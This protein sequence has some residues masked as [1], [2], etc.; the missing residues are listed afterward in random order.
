MKKL[1]AIILA[2]LTVVVLIAGCAKPELEAPVP[3]PVPKPAVTTQPPE[4]TPAP[5]TE[6]TPEPTPVTTESTP[7]PTPAPPPILTDPIETEY[8]LV[9]GE[10]IT[11]ADKKIHIYKGIPYAEP[12]LGDL[13]W[14]PPQPLAHWTGVRECTEYSTVAPQVDTYKMYGAGISEDCLYL[15]VL[16]PDEKP[17]ESLPVMVWLHGGGYSSGSGNDEPANLPGLPGHGVVLVT[18]NMRLGVL[19]LLAHPLL[20]EESTQGVSGNYMFLDMIAALKWVRDNIAAFGGDPDNVTIFGESGGGAKVA[21]LMASPLVKGLFHKAIMESGTAIDGLFPGFPGVHLKYMEKTGQNIFARLGVD[22][23]ADP[24]A[25]ARALPW[26]EFVKISVGT[27]ASI[28]GWFLT[29][30]PLNTFKAGEQNPVPFITVANLGEITG[31]GMFLALFPLLIPGYTH[32]LA[33]AGEVGVEAYA[34]IFEYVPAS[35]K[36]D[37]AVN[38]HGMEMPYVFGDMD[39]QSGTWSFLK[40]LAKF[41]GAKHGDPGLGEVDRQLSE[42]MMQ[43]WT[44]FARTGNPSVPGKVEWPVYNADADEY[45]ALGVPFQVKSGFSLLAAS[46]LREAKYVNTYTWEE[47]TEHI[48]ET[49]TITGPVI[50]WAD[51]AF[52]DGRTDPVLGVGESNGPGAFLVRLMIDRESLPEDLY[53]GKTISIIGE[54]GPNSYGG[55][56][57]WVDDMSQIEIIE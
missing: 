51:Y 5:V 36:A 9:C 14:K 17:A 44:Q 10:V 26:E 49:V 2:I 47:A 54:V 23:A 3:E 12:P 57:I 41:S 31:P 29:D 18:V 40:E 13:R 55:A 22:E 46:G 56:R 24:L 39:P 7:E 6:T 30:K 21:A 19:G 20:S 11:G 52:P 33:N 42:D 8:G 38:T 48:G 50:D 28:D 53:V 34:A 45:L 32:M 27:D 15:N 25:A 35:W 43:I 16:T 37:G 4:S 1:M